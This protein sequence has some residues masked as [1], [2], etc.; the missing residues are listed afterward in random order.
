MAATLLVEIGRF[1]FLKHFGSNS[2]EFI[3]FYFYSD[4]LLTILLYFALI[5]LYT[6]VFD[7]MKAE[8]YVRFGA[9][10]LLAGN[11]PFIYAV[12]HPCS[13]QILSPFFFSL[14]QNIY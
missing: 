5:S 8:K 12:L 3:Y 14:F 2:F 1:Q 10:L 6:V 4:A 13:S 11:R 7:E 9:V